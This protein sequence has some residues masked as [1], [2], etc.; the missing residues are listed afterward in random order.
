MAWCFY[1][2]NELLEKK[3]K[4]KVELNFYY[5]IQ[6]TNYSIEVLIKFPNAS[7]QFL[8]FLCHELVCAVHG[9]VLACWPHL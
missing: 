3:F 2:K 8:S 6:K 4:H 5:Y 1:N 7:S 9:P